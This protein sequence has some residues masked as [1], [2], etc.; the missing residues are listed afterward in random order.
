MRALISIDLQI[1]F[2]DLTGSSLPVTG[3]VKDVERISSLVD[4]DAFQQIFSS[5]DTHY[6]MDISHPKW[7]IDSKGD[8]VSPFTLIKADDIKNGKYNAII[9]PFASLKY[10]EDLEANGEFLH[11]I[12]PEHCIK[13]SVG[14]TL[15]PTYFAAL[16]E[17]MHRNKKWVSFIDKGVNPFTEHFGIFRANVPVTTDST[18]Q[19]NQSIFTVLRKADEIV[20]VGEART[21]CVANSLKQMLQIAPDLATKIFVVEDCMSNVGGLPDD[22]YAS[23]D[24]IYSDAV[25]QGVKIIKSSDL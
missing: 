13:G 25:T 20:I 18:T 19:P 6:N 21:H 8:S 4:K 7:W 16:N 5:L 17:W 1:D 11:F 2:M 23:V 14:Q 9:D 22:F 12:W 15:H 24:K 10:V 3:A